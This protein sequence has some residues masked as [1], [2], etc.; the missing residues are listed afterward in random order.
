MEQKNELNQNPGN[1]LDGPSIGFPAVYIEPQTEN[2]PEEQ[3]QEH[4]S[5]GQETPKD[6]APAENKPRTVPV[7][8]VC[9]ACGQPSKIIFG[10]HCFSR[11]VFSDGTE[12]LPLAQGCCERADH[13]TELCC[14]CINAMHREDPPK[15]KP[16]IVVDEMPAD[17][18][19]RFE[20]V[21]RVDLEA[22]KDG[23]QE[24]LQK[25]KALYAPRQPKTP[26]QRGTLGKGTSQ[27]VRE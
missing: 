13:R 5:P 21:L 27:G 8:G 12:P 6:S 14:N 17:P 19:R 18:C 7:P 20:Y 22:N 24:R 2:L 16:I 3:P 26:D 10:F 23:E 4:E 9:A 25:T 1:E 11:F 15:E